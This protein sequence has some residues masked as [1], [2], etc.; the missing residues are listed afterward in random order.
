MSSFSAEAERMRA[1]NARRSAALPDDFYSLHR[2]VNLFLRQ[3]QERAAVELLRQAG[4]SPLAGKRIL[5][6]GCGDG[7][8]LKY[9]RSWG[10]EHRLLAG[11]DLSPERVERTREDFPLADLR[12]GDATQLPWP[13]GH[14]DLVTQCTVLTSVLEPEARTRIAT[15]MTRVLAPSGTLLWCDFSYDNPSNRNVRGVKL[16][17]VRRLFPGFRMWK[18]RVTLAPP[19]ARRLVPLSWTLAWMLEQLKV[20]NTHWVIALRRA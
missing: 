1:E 18:R 13:D 17:E 5:D 19:L 4:A 9:L 8:W 12:A 3:G 10:G 16:D 14:F 6:V 11:I 2:P 15:E 7:T 20:L